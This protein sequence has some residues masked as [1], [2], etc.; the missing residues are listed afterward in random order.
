MAVVSGSNELA[1][2]LAKALGL[3]TKGLIGF[4]LNVRHDEVITIETEY[5]AKGEEGKDLGYFKR[6]IE[7]K[8]FEWKEIDS[9]VEIFDNSIPKA[10]RPLT[11]NL[12]K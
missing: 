3:E 4:T 10:R 9:E 11:Q 6:A 8:T 1:L 2:T 7:R 5:Y 12:V